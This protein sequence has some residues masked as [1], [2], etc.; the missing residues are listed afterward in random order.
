MRIDEYNKFCEDQDLTQS[1]GAQQ[2]S[3]NV[4]D[5][6][7]RR[8]MGEGTPLRVRIVCTE[9]VTTDDNNNFSI[10]LQSDDAEALDSSPTEHWNS[11]TL[12]GMAKGDEKVVFFP[13]DHSQYVGLDFNPEGSDAFTAGKITA[14][15]EGDAS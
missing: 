11:G 1:S 5:F 7:T 9:A 12:S 14:F 8:Q 4:L 13:Y 15:V 10:A 3:D 2:K 6:G